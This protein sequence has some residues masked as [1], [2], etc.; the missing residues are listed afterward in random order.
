MGPASPAAVLR[1]LPFALQLL[2]LA[3]VAV[4]L[5]TAGVHRRAAAALV[6]VL[7]VAGWA[8]Q[9]AFAAAG[10]PVFCGL[11]A[12]TA[13]AYAVCARVSGRGPAA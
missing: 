13:V 10:L 9:D 7:A 6:W 3:L 5:R 12:V 11:F 2:C 1:G 8:A 4:L